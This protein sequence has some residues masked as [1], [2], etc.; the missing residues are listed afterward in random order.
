MPEEPWTVLGGHKSYRDKRTFMLKLDDDRKIL[1]EDVKKYD[2]DDWAIASRYLCLNGEASITLHNLAK[3]LGVS[4]G[5]I[6]DAVGTVLYYID[7]PFPVSL[8]AVRRAEHLPK[9]VECGQEREREVEERR[10]YLATFSLTEADVPIGMS[11]DYIEDYVFI[12]RFWRYE[13]LGEYWVSPNERKVLVER[14]GFVHGRFRTLEEIGEEMGVTRERIRQLE[15]AA[16]KNLS[17][18]AHLLPASFK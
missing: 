18:L 16:I 11:M 17:K 10:V 4:G 6:Q 3:E 9:R 12:R 13:K 2:S 14:Y 15:T 5:H 7:S 1:L 8:A